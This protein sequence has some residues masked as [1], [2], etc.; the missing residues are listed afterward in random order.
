[1]ECTSIW[2]ILSKSCTTVQLLQF[3]SLHTYTSCSYTLHSMSTVHI[4]VSHRRSA[5]LYTQIGMLCFLGN[6]L[7]H[8]SAI[9]RSV[10]KWRQEWVSSSLGAAIRYNE[11]CRHQQ[12]ENILFTC[13]K[14]F[15][16]KLNCRLFLGA[17]SKLYRLYLS[18]P[19]FWK[20]PYKGATRKRGEVI[21]LG[22]MEWLVTSVF[23][24]HDSSCLLQHIA[25]YTPHVSRLSKTVWIFGWWFDSFKQ[26]SL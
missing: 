21:H 20:Q 1:M 14:G 10:H 4:W 5:E 11:T 9:L 2:G 19:N 23:F 7:V 24:S 3:Y 25:S 18:I 15:P 16:L 13:M 12:S 22:V 26:S 17:G 6:R 8:L